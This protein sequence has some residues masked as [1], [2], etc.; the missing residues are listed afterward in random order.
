MVKVIASVQA[1]H[2]LNFLNLLQNVNYQTF[3]PK[4]K[5]VPLTYFQPFA[6]P[7]ESL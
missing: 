1:K 4:L 6:S 7:L 5:S 3:R 2:S